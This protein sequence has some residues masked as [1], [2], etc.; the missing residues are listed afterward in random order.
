MLLKARQRPLR[1]LESH[2]GIEACSDGW[3]LTP[4]WLVGISGFRIWL[5]RLSFFGPCGTFSFAQWHGMG[6]T[7]KLLEAF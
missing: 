6:P 1:A 5:G 3:H 7:I 2:S 4:P